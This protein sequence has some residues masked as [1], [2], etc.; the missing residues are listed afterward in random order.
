M[1]IIIFAR[2]LTEGIKVP[3]LVEGPTNHRRCFDRLSNLQ[4]FND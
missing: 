3:E 1:N 4:Q 2:F